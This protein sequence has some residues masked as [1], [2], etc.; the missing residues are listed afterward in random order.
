LLEPA[1]LP[2]TKPQGTGLDAIVPSAEININGADIDHV[3]LR[4]L[5]KLRW[6]V[7]THGLRIEQGGEKHQATKY[8]RFCYNLSETEVKERLASGEPAVV[9]MLVP[10]GVSEWKDM[11]HGRVIFNNNVLDD[12]VL[13]KS[14]GYPTYHFANVVDDH[15]M[16]ISHV[17]RG[18]EWLSSTPKHLILYQM[19]GL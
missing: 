17:I 7:E 9:R 3:P 11:V 2:E 16:K 12:Q 10:H 1:D 4:I 14:D 19:F 5:H 13:I 6:R 15:L 18:E 8:D